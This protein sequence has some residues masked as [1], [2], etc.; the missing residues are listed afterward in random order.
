MEICGKDGCL[1]KIGHDDECSKNPAEAWNFFSDKDKDKLSKAGYATP[2]G[3]KKGA[4]QNH[5]Y[6]YSKV[7]IPYEKL[8]K[9]SLEHYKNGYIIR[10]L[11]EQCFS[12]KNVLKTEFQGESQV[13][14][15][16]NAFVL[17]RSHESFEKF[18]PLKGWQVR[19]LENQDGNVVKRRSRNVTDKG[20][21]ILRLPAIG[22]SS[23]VTTKERI[24]GPPQG[25]FAP[26]Y[27][28]QDT[29]Y[30][31][32]VVL[33]WQIV[34]T[35]NSPY[36]SNQAEHIQ[37]IL[38][39]IELDEYEFYRQRGVMNKTFTT[40]PLCMRPIYYEELHQML[41]FEDESGL[42]NSGEQVAGATRS[43][44]INLFHQ[45]PLVYEQLEHIPPNVAWG[46]ATCNTKL[47]QRRC[48]SL[49]ELQDMNNKVGVVKGEQFNTFGWISDDTSMIRSPL[50]SVWIQITQDADWAKYPFL[51]S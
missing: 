11:P 30:L 38:K 42:L 8:Q 46:H 10:L 6:R 29:D 17:Y 35:V 22:G 33:A 16:N 23:T 49:K 9:A 24:E 34:H 14:I 47:G 25:I 48:Y 18:P 41:S 13:V 44:T 26:E 1:R 40:C 21:Y 2:R 5:V 45:H 27:A 4:Y 39:T 7:I 28:D 50:G 15:G 19:H 3:G 43:T 31:C 36:T 32:R 51:E 12:S 20:H 37:A